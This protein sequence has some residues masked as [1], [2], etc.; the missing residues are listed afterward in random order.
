[1]QDNA[2]GS[3]ISSESKA[4]ELLEE[5]ELHSRLDV[6][7]AR[8]KVTVA[9]DAAI[10]ARPADIVRRGSLV[11]EGT[12]RKL[13][14]QGVSTICKSPVEVGSVFYIEFHSSTLDLHPALAVCDRCVMLEPTA[15]GVHFQ[16]AQAIE[17][18]Q[19]DHEP[20]EPRPT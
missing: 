8:E 18:P 20:A 19:V 16:F 14:R 10:E 1:M 17:L 4:H 11:V 15:F 13:A 12:A 9:I 7:A 2:L 6:R 3:T 5:L